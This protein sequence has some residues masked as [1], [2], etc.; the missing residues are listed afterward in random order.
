MEKNNLTLENWKELYYEL[1]QEE[2]DMVNLSEK[3][4]EFIE[5]II[6]QTRQET[7]E[8]VK[9]IIKKVKEEAQK[10]PAQFHPNY[11]LKT[12]GYNLGYEDALNEV[13]ELIGKL[14]VKK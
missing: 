14:E 1:W 7:L 12:E 5:K 9:E 3:I 2:E 8:K 11:K 4:K 10:Y 13:I 6:D